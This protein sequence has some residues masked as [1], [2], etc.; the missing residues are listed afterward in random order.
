MLQDRFGVSERR[1]CRVVG[2]HRSTQRLEAPAPP[3]DEAEL[4]EF[5]RAFAKRRPRWGWRRAAKELRR[6]GWQVNDK[7]VRRLW[8]D[9]GLNLWQF[10]SLLEA[11]VLIGDWHIDYNENDPT[12]PTAIS[13]PPS[14]PRPGPPTTSPN[15]KPHSAW[16]THRGPPTSSNQSRGAVC[17]KLALGM[18][19]APG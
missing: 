6:E 9:E 11:Q 15:P 2:Q 18:D 14:S 8:R 19:S 7:R 3:A 16:T 10:D 13:P 1:A 12:Q 17:T 4:R 5:L